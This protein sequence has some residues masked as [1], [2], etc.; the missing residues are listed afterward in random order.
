MAASKIKKR[1]FTF[2]TFYRK[3]QHVLMRCRNMQG[4][5]AGA[6]NHERSETSG[7]IFSGFQ[8]I[9]SSLAVIA[10]AEVSSQRCLAGELNEN[11]IGP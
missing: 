1:G 7:G 11:R 10:F 6:D 4:F 9:V 5:E 2:K 3:G 8:G